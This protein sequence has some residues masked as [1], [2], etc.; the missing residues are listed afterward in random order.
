MDTIKLKITKPFWQVFALGVLAGMRSTSAPAIASHILS[1]H[2]SKKLE[3]SP[4]RFMQSEN[5]ANVLKVIALGEL[6]GDKLPAAPNRIEPVGLIARCL[7]GALAGA[8][9]F[10]ANGGKLLVGALLGAGTA[11]VATYGSYYLRKSL[12]ANTKIFDPYIGALEDVLVI[13][14]GAGLTKL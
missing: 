14:A 10:K 3:G 8:S 4:L 7:S 12:V 11:A 13:G 5:L 6:V 9:I 2:H 1:H